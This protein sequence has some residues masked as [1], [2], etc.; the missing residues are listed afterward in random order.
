MSIVIK[1]EAL[2]WTFR[3]KEIGKYITWMYSGHLFVYIIV[4]NCMRI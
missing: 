2:S 4:L 1:I 3:G